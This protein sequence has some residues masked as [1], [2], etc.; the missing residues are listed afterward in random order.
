MPVRVPANPVSEIKGRDNESLY[1]PIN[2]VRPYKLRGAP[3]FER[4]RKREGKA[5]AI[6]KQSEG[7]AKA[8]RTSNHWFLQIFGVPRPSKKASEDPKRL[9]RGYL[10]LL[11]AILSYLGAILE[12]SWSDLGNK[13]F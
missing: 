6:L 12:R 10:A 5:K 4:K 2:L 3:L 13:S 9:P 7:K 11:G 1:S 8:K